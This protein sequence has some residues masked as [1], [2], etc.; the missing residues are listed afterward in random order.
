[1]SSGG[2][3]PLIERAQEIDTLS[4]ALGDARA[5]TGQMVLVE[6]SP[7]IGKSQLLEAGRARAEQSGMRVLSGG[8]P[9][10]PPSGA[11]HG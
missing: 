5:G 11:R 4:R 7:G 3:G 9:I 2:G 1:M 6:G 8:V 10:V